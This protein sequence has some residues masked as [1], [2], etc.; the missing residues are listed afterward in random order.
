MQRDVLLFDFWF[1][2]T[3]LTADT[4]PTCFITEDIRFTNIDAPWKFLN[5]KI[6]VV[7]AF[8]SCCPESGTQMLSNHKLHY[9]SPNRPAQR[10]QELFALI[11]V[12]DDD[13]T[14]N[15]LTAVLKALGWVVG[16]RRVTIQK[17]HH[18]YR[19]HGHSQPLERL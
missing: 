8:Q 10:L 15:T 7:Q 2:W 3:A 18:H 5:P 1:S 12:Q 14:L 11:S 9:I 16:C 4:V 13:S 17:H 19:Q 6:M